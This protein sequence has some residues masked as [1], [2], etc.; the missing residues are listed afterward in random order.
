MRFAGSSAE[1][2]WAAFRAFAGILARGDR[3]RVAAY[4]MASLMAAF[5]GS[6]AALLLVPLIQP[7]SGLPVAGSLPGRPWSLAAHAALFAT[8]SGVFAL[9]RWSGACLGARLAANCGVGLRAKVHSR[10][11]G[12]RLELLADSTS[13]E[14]A[15]VLTY[16]VEIIVHGFS[17]TLQLLVACITT[18][19]TLAFAFWVSPPLVLALPVFAAFAWMAARLFGHEQARLGR[20]YVADMTRLFWR[21]EDFPRRLRHVRSFGRQQSDHVSFAGMAMRLG[22]GYRRQL[23]LAAHGRLLLELLAAAAIA[24]GFLL[25]HRWSGFDQARLIAVCL[26]LG[27]LLPYLVSTRQSLQQLRLAVPAFDLWRRYAGLETDRPVPAFAAGGSPG[28]LRIGRVRLPRSLVDV[29]VRDLLLRPGELTLVR[30]ESGI[31]KSCL[32][33]VLSGMVAPAMF[34]ADI[35]G[36]KIGFEEYRALVGKGAYVSQQVRPWHPS[37]RACLHWAAPAAS[38]AMLWDALADVGLDTRVRRS[39]GGLDTALHGS[40][41]RLSGGELQRLMLAQVLLRQP[42]LAILDEATAALD[43]GAERKVLSALRRRLPQTILIVVSHRTGPA[44]MADQCLGIDG[45]GVAVAVRRD[46]VDPGPGPAGISP[47]T[48]A[49]T[50]P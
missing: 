50:R 37:V 40:G 33:D 34:E 4:V 28:A 14:V 29:E 19:V 17:A 23:E 21:G 45:R 36:R 43:A 9:L 13:A 10:L 46:L 15:N 47:G 32:V 35:A 7:A 22:H 12:A 30:G 27:R 24:A 41:S 39:A 38:D 20:E 18:L 44:A 5:A 26:L 31:G 11:V 1:A 48:L 42:V 2:P 25:A 16:N 49:G 6:L 3:A 8:A